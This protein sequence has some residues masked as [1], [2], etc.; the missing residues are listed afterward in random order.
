MQVFQL[1]DPSRNNDAEQKFKTY[2]DT[3]LNKLGVVFWKAT[4]YRSYFEGRGAETTFTLN[5]H[6]FC[7]EY[8]DDR[9]EQHI[10]QERTKFTEQFNGSMS[11]LDTAVTVEKGS[12]LRK[13]AYV[14]V[15]SPYHVTVAHA[16]T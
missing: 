8:L 12:N 4:L 13:P 15:D 10:L 14:Y 2:V 9:C 7:R 1:S 3:M 11:H 16:D 5:L 6:L